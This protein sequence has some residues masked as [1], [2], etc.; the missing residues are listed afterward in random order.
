[1][2]LPAIPQY[3]LLDKVCEALDIDPSLVCRIILDLSYSSGDPVTVYVQMVATTKILE[4]DWNDCL[5]GA[6]VRVV[7]K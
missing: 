3:E 6:K 4:L 5:K 2:A 1:M 7:D